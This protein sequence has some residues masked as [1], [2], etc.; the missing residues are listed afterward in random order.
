MPPGLPED[1]SAAILNA[2][3]AVFT[4]IATQAKAV[5]GTIPAVVQPL[6]A[7]VKDAVS[8]VLG[9]DRASNID[10]SGDLLAFVGSLQDVITDERRLTAG[11]LSFADALRY[12]NE[13]T[14]L[15]TIV[16][17]MSFA[18]S[19]VV[20]SVTLG[21]VEGFVGL[22]IH[23]V[24]DIVGDAARVVSTQLVRKAVGDPFTKG[25]AR[26]HRST[27]LSASEAGESHA[28]GLIDDVRLVDVLISGSFTDQAIQEKVQLARVKA[29]NQ[30][31]VFPLRT[32]FVSPA[33]LTQA[34]KAGIV[35]DEEFVEQLARQGYD[36]TALAI[37]WGLAQLKLPPPEAPVG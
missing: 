21:Q 4:G 6:S 23:M 18:F 5:I 29:L 27:D 32:K 36:D 1:I 30:A 14:G 20:E 17:L 24:D 9:A 31:G 16:V 7:A 35:S 19:I 10:T 28:L 34:L 11:P 37:L 3:S 13:I 33:T 25:Y 12:E 22:L 15:R 2:F 8:Q 26:I